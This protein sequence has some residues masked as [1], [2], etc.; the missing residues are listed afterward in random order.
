MKSE[1]V[2]D[3]YLASKGKRYAER[4]ART[5]DAG[6]KLQSAF[7][8]PYV[9]LN[10]RVLDF[11]CGQGGIGVHLPCRRLDGFDVNPHQLE[12]ARRHYS[13]VFFD[14]SQPPLGFYDVVYSNH[15]LEH[16]P[17]PL[18]ALTKVYEWLRPGGKALFVVPHDSIR[19]KHQAYYDE[20]DPDHHFCTWTPRSLGNLF[21]EAGFQVEVCKLLRSAWH[22]RLLKVHQLP[23]VGPLSRR[24]VCHLLKRTQVFCASTKRV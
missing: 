6:H 10:D 20:D 4:Y 18:L 14:Y 19:D 22:P 1:Y 15:V 11:G 17:A 9:S 3:H 12:A 21:S 7:F 13:S 8:R 16:I 23:M 5:R 2:S 24:V